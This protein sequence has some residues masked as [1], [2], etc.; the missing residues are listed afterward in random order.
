[1]GK[2]HAWALVALLAIAGL[3]ACPA[4]TAP[5]ATGAGVPANWTA[6]FPPFRI[7][8]DLYYIGSQDLASY[9]VVTSQGNILINSDLVASVPML[10]ASIEKLG[11]RYRDTKILLISHAHWDHA[12]GS[13]RIRQETGA[14]YM[15]MEADVA[16]IESGGAKDFFYGGVA[17]DRYPPATV[18][19]VLHDGSTVTLGGSELVAHLTPGHTQGCTTWTMTVSEGGK[20]YRV[21]MVGSPNVNP[22]Y[23]LVDN[24]NYPQIAADYE[25]TWRVLEALPCDIFL[26]A[27]GGYFGLQAKYARR[28]P[29]AANR[30]VDPDGYRRFVADAQRAFETELARQRA[31]GR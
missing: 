25:R 6:P 24:A 8:G 16:V 13:A 30:F 19:R 2:G 29:G 20:S 18:D 17:A 15:V 21:V 5:A 14:A 3:A 7:A 22:G 31:A 4:Q 10:R 26:G 9:L 27:H 12:A 28:R 11:F 23:R 1:M